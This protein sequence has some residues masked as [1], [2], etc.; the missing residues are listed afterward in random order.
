MFPTIFKRE[1]L[2][3]AE[4]LF[5][6]AGT[7]VLPGWFL[8]VVFPRWKYSANII[9]AVVIPVLLAFLYGWL[10]L[11][12]I[13]SNDGGFGSLAEVRTLFSND[14]LLLAG[15][16]HYLAF[17]LFIGSWEVRDSQRHGIHHLVVVICL[18]LTFMLGPIGLLLYLATRAGWKKQW[19]LENA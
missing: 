6:I 7:L 11:T 8:L 12:H 4:S 17:D 9:A 16:V 3:S 18:L 13:G 15:W 10:I 19:S 5:S 2:L 14:F 1:R